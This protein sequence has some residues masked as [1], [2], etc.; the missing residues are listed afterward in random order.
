MHATKVGF[1]LQH[2]SK[3]PEQSN[4]SV[5]IEIGFTVWHLICLV[6]G[7]GGGGL[8]LFLPEKEKKVP[9][10]KAKPMRSPQLNCFIFIEGMITY[11]CFLHVS[12]SLLMIK[13]FCCLKELCFKC[14]LIHLIQEHTII[15]SILCLMSNPNPTCNSL[16]AFLTIHLDPFII[17]GE[18]RHCVLP[19]NTKQ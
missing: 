19:K 13:S 10:S 2:A 9:Q 12:V 1:D 3:T 15:L 5:D 14:I 16:S 11:I 8:K 7:G 6:G 18:E 17:L 4:A